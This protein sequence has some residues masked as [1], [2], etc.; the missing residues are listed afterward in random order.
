MSEN[1]YRHRKDAIDFDEIKSQRSMLDTKLIVKRERIHRCPED[2]LKVEKEIT[3]LYAKISELDALLAKAPPLPALPPSQPLVK[4]SGVLE[5][6][7]TL[8]TKGYFTDREYEPDEFTRQ[9]SQ[10]QWGSVLLAAV[11]ESAAATVNAQDSVRESHTYDFVQGK[12]NGK[13]FYG[14]LGYCPAQCGDDVDMAATDHGDHYEVY[15]L[16]LPELRVI[17]TIPCCAYGVIGKANAAAMGGIPFSVGVAIIGLIVS[18]FAANS[19]LQM[20]QITGWFFLGAVIYMALAGPIV[21]DRMKEKP[22]PTIV[23]GQRIFSAL[24]FP[25]P[26]KVNLHMSTRLKLW[27]GKN[28][29]LPESASRMMPDKYYYVSHY[30]YY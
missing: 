10:R 26:E 6:L 17:T 15:A 7:N 25:H 16:A 9:E 24:E 11:G 21:Y 29:A 1:T 2:R 19:I 5:E 27:F 28:E 14:W 22:K 30:F 18:F 23:L 8:F 4:V 12:I 20:L 3:E 13:P